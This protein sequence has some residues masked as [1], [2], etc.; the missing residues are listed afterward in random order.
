MEYLSILTFLLGLILG[1]RLAIGRDKRKEFNEVAYPVYKKIS[2][3]LENSNSAE[4][5]KYTE[6]E[7]LS[8]FMPIWQ[9]YRYQRIL[10]AYKKNLSDLVLSSKYDPINEIAT[11]D[12]NAKSLVGKNLELLKKHARR[13]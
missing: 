2:I 5:P 11:C 8:N 10:L 7:C 3:Y 1:N 6:L 9:R 4:L 12:L 13:R